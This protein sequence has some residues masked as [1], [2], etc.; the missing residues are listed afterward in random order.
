MT[1]LCQI[2]TCLNSRPLCP[3]P[4]CNDD[5]PEALTP[6]HFLI[7]HSLM[8]LPGKESSEVPSSTLHRWH[9]HQNLIQHFWKRWSEEY[10]VELNKYM[11]WLH[12]SRN[13]GVGDIVLLRDATLFPTRWPLAR[14]IDV[15]DNLVR[16]V[17]LR[18]EKGEYKRP[19]T[20]IAML[21]PSESNN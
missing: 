8:A 21:L 4:T 5:P 18:T 16:V 11:K 13:V 10:I 3:L 19:V 6:G 15:H 1:A 7:G 9:L 2:R 20:K 14:V 17:T 12:E